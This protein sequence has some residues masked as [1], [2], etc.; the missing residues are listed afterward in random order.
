M[1]C[2]GPRCGPWRRLAT[3]SEVFA[4]VPAKCHLSTCPTFHSRLECQVIVS[5]RVPDSDSLSFSLS[6][7]L[8]LP[9]P[10]PPH[11]KFSM[12]AFSHKLDGFGWSLRLDGHRKADEARSLRGQL[13]CSELL[14]IGLDI[15]LSLL[16]LGFFFF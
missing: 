2:P 8:S 9:P 15:V 13:F 11:L 12:S 1:E 7:S 4:I 10:P 14:S 16:S 5:P 3:Q 6:L